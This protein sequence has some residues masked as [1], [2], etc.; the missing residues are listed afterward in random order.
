SIPAG[1]MELRSGAKGPVTASR[2]RRNAIA[3]GVLCAAGILPTVLGMPA[4]WQAFG[5]GLF[6]PGA[7]FLAVGGG[8][9]VPFPLPVGAFWLSVVAWLW[10]GMVV[11]PLTVWLGS[12]AVAAA[13]IGKAVWAPAPFLAPLFAAATFGIFRYRGMRTR[14]ADR[15]RLEMRKG[16]FATS[17]AE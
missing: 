15:E 12:A 17:L 13:M 6:M 2:H 11:A 9:L 7:G 4:G 14:A 3:Y 16:F 5:L 1:E 8:G 10:A